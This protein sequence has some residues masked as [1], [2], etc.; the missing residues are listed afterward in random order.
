MNQRTHD[1][2]ARRRAERLSAIGVSVL[3]LVVL[4]AVPA[5]CEPEPPLLPSSALR[6]SLEQWTALPPNLTGMVRPA[7]GPE[8]TGPPFLKGR[9]LI[10]ANVGRAL[11]PAGDLGSGAW[12]V[13]PFFRFTP[14]HGGWG[15]SFGFTGLRTDLM[16]PVDGRSI[17][18]GTVRIRP[19]MGGIGYSIRRGPTITSF[20]MVGGYAF[21]SA[22]VDHPLPVG[23]TIDVHMKNAWVVRPHVGVTVAATRRFAIVGSL[24]YVMTNPTI[25]VSIRQDGQLP[26][27]VSG[28]YRSHYLS[29]NVGAGFS[30][31]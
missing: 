4:S 19:V 2:R 18:V 6:I 3:A 13:M 31:F 27:T 14:R 16:A 29:F 5:W 26:R 25:T 22:R 21:S 1:A 9:F 8:E 28:S 17:P 23:T 11:T 12:R 24:G 30:I 10:G 7:A 15:P 20:S